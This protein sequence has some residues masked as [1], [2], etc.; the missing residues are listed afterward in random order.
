MKRV[1][2]KDVGGLEKI[3]REIKISIIY[4]LERPDLYE[5]YKRGIKSSI[6]LY[7][8]P[9]CG[10][11]LLARA[12]AGEVKANFYNIKIT[13]VISKWYGETDKNIRIA[14]EEAR[15]NAPSVLFFDEIDGIASHKSGEQHEI[16]VLNTLLTELDGF[17]DRGDVMILAA[18]NAPWNIDPALMRPGRF[19]KLLFVP[20]PDL[21][22]RE[23]IFRIH[24]RGR[25]VSSDVDV[26]RLARMTDGYSAAEIKEICDEAASIPFEE[27]MEG[28]PV[29]E[30]NMNDFLEV[31]SKK[32]T[33]LIYWFKIAKIRISEKRMEEFFPELLRYF[34]KMEEE[35]EEA[36]IGYV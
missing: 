17:E 33:S 18:T 26:K 1:T 20:P 25:L 5:L 29:R 2:F 3:K 12:T 21:K 34:E 6:L 22:A 15:K 24:L 10:K 28:K 9:G 13:D 23:E 36:I 7:G 32:K 8:P 11:T 4:P 14:F 31:I 35:K 30:I 19:D 27:A 16:R